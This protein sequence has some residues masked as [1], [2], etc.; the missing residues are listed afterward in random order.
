MVASD[1]KDVKQCLK[2][3]SEQGSPEGAVGFTGSLPNLAHPGSPLVKE[4]PS[5]S[6]S[7]VS[8]SEANHAVGVVQEHFWYRHERAAE[9]PFFSVPSVTTIT[10]TSAKPKHFETST[11]TCKTPVQRL[12]STLAHC[13]SEPAV[14][15]SN[16]EQIE[17][18]ADS[19]DVHRATR[20]L[21]PQVTTSATGTSGMVS[22]TST[23][24]SASAA[25]AANHA[26]TVFAGRTLNFNFN[27][28]SAGLGQGSQ[29]TRAKHRSSISAG[30]RAK[31]H[32]LKQGR[33]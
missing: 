8:S 22:S 29:F 12:S 21:E 14:P 19:S 17:E 18:E 6:S 24:P 11:T 9:E 15:P 20:S 2:I 7:R 3:S 4:F 13:Q 23:C 10:T 33:R 1:P 26:A 30:Q 31:K 28:T 27:I 5:Q 25:S 16:G 32:C